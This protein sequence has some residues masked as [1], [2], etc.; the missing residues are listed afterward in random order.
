[1]GRGFDDTEEA[2]RCRE[3]GWKRRRLRARDREPLAALRPPAAQHLAAVL[4][5]HAPAEAMHLLA[6]ALVRLIGA[7]SF[8]HDSSDKQSKAAISS[9]GSQRTLR[10]VTSLGQAP[11][12][13]AERRPSG[14][15]AAGAP[16]ATCASRQP[17][18]GFRP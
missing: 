15:L 7:L 8:R 6:A 3:A 2:R 10:C 17:M 18:K 9:P 12:G 11:G 16:P 5:L 4:G 1:M 13:G 14:H